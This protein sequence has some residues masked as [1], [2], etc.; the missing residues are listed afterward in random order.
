MTRIVV[1]SAVRHA[2]HE[3]FSGYVRIV[4]LDDGTTLHVEPVP[5]SPWRGVDPNPR[6]G[7]RGAKGVSVYGDRLVVCNSDSVFVVDERLELVTTFSH[8]LAGA[9]HDVLA[10]E[11][12]IWVTCTNADLLA[13]FTWEGELAETWSWR[14]DHVLVGELGFD[15][16]PPTD[17]SLDYRDPR[18][19]QSGVTNVVHLNGVTRGR[20]GLLL[21]F[22]RILDPAA[23]S[24]Q[25][26]RA[27]LGWMAARLG[28][29]RRRGPGRAD[30]PASEIPGS[31]SA[32]VLR[33][34]DGT[35][36]LML[37]R[38][39]IGLPDHNVLAG[40]AMLIVNE[41]NDGRLVAHDLDPPAEAAAATVPGS[42]SFAR[43]LAH[44]RH[45]VYLVGSQR[46]LAVHAIDLDAAVV[47]E[48][49]ELG[50]EENESVYAIAVLP[51]TFSTPRPG[52][53]LFAP[54]TAAVEAK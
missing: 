8:P 43:G 10:E 18:V 21:C 40:E 23:V 45:Q 39:G 17:L 3:R 12:G 32:V 46:P 37:H 27:R 2:G 48:T 30:M 9:I 5:E 16:I 42:P 51:D 20:E 34:D 47:A 41:T 24:R 35:A 31:S 14:D 29:I 7:T 26:R 44:L 4:D 19:L 50:G 25:A 49:F 13:R 28:V 33:R 53:S 11:S 52:A 22:G 15:S 1:T 54:S 38:T 36:L 6:G